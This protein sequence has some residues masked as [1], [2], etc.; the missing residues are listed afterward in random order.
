M[1]S[2]LPLVM[3]SFTNSSHHWLGS[4]SR[5]TSISVPP[6]KKCVNHSKRAISFHFFG[7]RTN[8]VPSVP[9]EYPI[10]TQNRFSLLAIQAKVRAIALAHSIGSPLILPDS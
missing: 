7:G 3:P 5:G 2:V 8:F 9:P 10:K 1:R 4:C 6:E